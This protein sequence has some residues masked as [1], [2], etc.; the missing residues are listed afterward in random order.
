V[1]IFVNLYPVIVIVSAVCAFQKN[2]TF[3]NTH[4]QSRKVHENL[5]GTQPAREVFT[6][7]FSSICSPSH[8]PMALRARSLAASPRDV[9]ARSSSKMR[10][11]RRA[12]KSRFK[13][14]QLPPGCLRCRRHRSAFDATHFRIPE[15]FRIACALP[16][17]TVFKFVAIMRHSAAD[18]K[19]NTAMRRSALA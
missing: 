11:P 16:L 7:F 15:R 17:L 2:R 5:V 10:G 13:A 9:R 14:S 18:G 12:K 19:W 1:H 4:F 8:I 3:T 6:R